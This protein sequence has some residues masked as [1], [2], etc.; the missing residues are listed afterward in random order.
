MVEDDTDKDALNLWM[1]KAIPQEQWD[2]VKDQLL[3]MPTN[4]RPTPDKV[5]TILDTLHRTGAVPRVRAFVVADRDYRLKEELDAESE[6]LRK[7]AFARQTWHVWQRVEIENY[8]LCPDVSTRL[9]LTAAKEVLGDA[10]RAPPS[11]ADVRS[12]IEHAVAAS[13]EQARGQFI[14]SFDRWQREQKKGWKTPT[15]VERAEEY[16]ASVWRA[17]DRLA[18]CDAKDVLAR[19][20]DVAKKRGRSRSPHGTS[21]GSFARGDRSR[22]QKSCPGHPILFQPGLSSRVA[23]RLAD[24]S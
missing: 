21:S 3:Y 10:A 15:V 18:W 5:N 11:D 1:Q 13:R 22:H 12:E 7:P 6:K 20:R 16:L 9:I 19:L 8:L 23:I 17:E 24:K 4:G 14:E 2:R